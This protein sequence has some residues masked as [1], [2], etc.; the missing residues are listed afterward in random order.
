MAD[1]E[2][3]LLILLVLG[4][5]PVA[6]PSHPLGDGGHG[7]EEVWVVPDDGVAGR[8]KDAVHLNKHKLHLASVRFCG[9][10]AVGVQQVVR[11]WVRGEGLAPVVVSAD[12]PSVVDDAEGVG[13][14]GGDD[15]HDP[16]GVL[17]E[18]RREPAVDGAHVHDV[19]HLV[20]PQRGQQRLEIGRAHV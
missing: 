4:V 9:E 11:T 5:M 18:A 6:G 15:V 17:D 2:L 8:A 1:E 7:V 10:Q 16:H 14:V 19:P 3:L 13:P 12:E 20:A